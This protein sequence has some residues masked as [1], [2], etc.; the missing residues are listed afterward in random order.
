MLV[1][2]TEYFDLDQVER[3]FC[4]A[5]QAHMLQ[6]RGLLPGPKT[7]LLSDTRGDTSADKARD[8]IGKGHSGGEQ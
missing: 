3:D 6:E 5:R 4:S 8:F 2:G 7:G 1:S